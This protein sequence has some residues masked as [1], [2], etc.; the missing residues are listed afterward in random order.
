MTEPKRYCRNPSGV[1]FR[2]SATEPTLPNCTPVVVLDPSDPADVL[3][4]ADALVGVYAGDH[5]AA[6]RILAALLPP[7]PVTDETFG[8]GDVVRDKTVPRRVY[9]LAANGYY[10]HTLQRVR[11]SGELM[12]TSKDYERVG[13]DES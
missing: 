6:L 8:P 10:D 9:T 13:G 2:P 5:A 1:V 3:R 4:L 12:F 7:E 11:E